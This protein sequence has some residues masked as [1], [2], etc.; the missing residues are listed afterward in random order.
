MAAPRATQDHV[1]GGSTAGRAVAPPCRR[2]RQRQ[3]RHSEMRGCGNRL[4]ARSRWHECQERDRMQQPMLHQPAGCSGHLSS[5]GAH[6][7]NDLLR[8]CCPS[9]AGMCEVP[10]QLGVRHHHVSHR[11]AARAA[12]AAHACGCGPVLRMDVPLTSAPSPASSATGA[13]CSPGACRAANSP[14]TRCGSLRGALAQ[15]PAEPGAQRR[16]GSAGDAGW[17][18][19]AAGFV[20]PP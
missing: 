13:S 2:G 4:M 8:T 15:R 20:P 3:E 14:R 11:G 7:T 5:G 9:V 17:R 16:C 19:A 1:H 10:L 6:G 12:R 18:G